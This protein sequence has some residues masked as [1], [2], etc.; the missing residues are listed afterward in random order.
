MSHLLES[1]WAPKTPTK[2]NRV[3]VSPSKPGLAESRW[4]AVGDEE[5]QEKQH[6]RSSSSSPTSELAHPVIRTPLRHGAKQNNQRPTTTPRLS[7]IPLSR[8]FSP[9]NDPG[10]LNRPEVESPT[11]KKQQGKH[12]EPT[13]PTKIA[14]HQAKVDETRQR[15]RM[16]KLN[17][18]H[19]TD[20]WHQSSVASEHST[21]TSPRREKKHHQR[22]QPLAPTADVPSVAPHPTQSQAPTTLTQEERERLEKQIEDIQNGVFDWADDSD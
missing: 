10:E 12:F 7:D 16:K 11:R 1:K 8:R 17:T 14:A 4:S 5:T 13:S 6:P 9:R 2:E 21:F 20:G 19:P 18:D 22:Q 15:Y 3:E